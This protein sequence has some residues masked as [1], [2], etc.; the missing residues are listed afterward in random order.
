MGSLG[1]RIFL[2]LVLMTVGVWGAAAVW[3]NVHTSSEV[4]RVLDRRLVEAARMVGSLAQSQGAPSAAGQL[5]VP[6]ELPAGG[7]KTPPRR[8]DRQLSCQIWSLD[9]RLIGRSAGAPSQPLAT[10]STGFSERS[11]GGQLWR[12]YTLDDPASGV[13]VMVGDSLAVR[14]H[15]VRDVT[16]GLLLPAVLGILVLAGLIWSGVGKGLLPLRRIAEALERRKADDFTALQVAPVARELTPVVDA[17]NDLFGRLAAVRD[18]ERHLIASAAHELQ[19]PLAGIRMHAQI[20]LAADDPDMRARAERQIISSVDRAARLVRQLLDLARHEAQAE[21]PAP[22][23]LP[24]KRAFDIIE[25]ELQLTLEKADVTIEAD[26]ALLASEIFVNEESLLLAL[27]NLVEN[28]VQHSPRSG[29]VS[30]GLVDGKEV[31]SIFVD[32]G[33][34]GIPEEDMETVR[35][36]FVRG[37]REQGVGSGLG[38]SIVDLTLSQSGARLVLRNRSGGGLRAAIEFPRPQVRFHQDV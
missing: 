6:S 13:R 21:A 24:L 15:L 28:A 7:F 2:I 36:R 14:H 38:L 17:L 22:R 20:A 37:R 5:A 27:R 26:A 34:P 1:F 18:A 10:G 32:D 8:Y 35:Q 31:V 12:V 30:C 33:G 3:T 29:T 16:T 19:T 11:V 23:W 4:E 9:G 25:A